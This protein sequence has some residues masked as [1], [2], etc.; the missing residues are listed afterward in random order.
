MEGIS[1]PQ[2]L[3]LRANDLAGEW[4]RWVRSFSDYLLAID[5]VGTSGA[6]ER[7]KL[8]LFR[9][10]GGEDVRELY[11]QM[12]FVGTDN[13]GN[14]EEIA[15]GATGRKIDDVLKRFREYCNPRSGVIV[16]RYTFHNC[17][18][19]GEPVDVY[20]MKLRR[21][22]ESCEF[23]NQRDSLIRD[24]LLFGLDDHKLRDKMMREPDER[25]TLDY[26]IK[27]LRIAE[28]SK[29]AQNSSEK[30]TEV[31][32][33]TSH[34]NGSKLGNDKPKISCNKCGRRHVRN[35]C[36]AFGTTCRKCKRK[37]HWESV[38][39]NEVT[40]AVSELQVADNNEANS[41]EVF[42]GEIFDIDSV[43][44]EAGSW[45]SNVRV[46]TDIK[47]NQL[48]RFKLDTGA[49]LSVCGPQHCVGTQYPS[50]K[51]L[52]G[53]GRTLLNCI[54]I[55]SGKLTAGREKIT[56]DIY[57]IEN[58]NTPLLSR[59]ACESLKFVT[60]DKSR[61][62]IGSIRVS[63]S[64]FKGLG[65]LDTE[66]S[67]T[68]DENAKPF[69]LHV[70]RPIPFPLR[71]KANIALEKMVEDG[72]IVAIEEPTQW[73][74]PMVVVPKPGQDK[75]RICTDFT[76]LNKYVLREVHP[77]AT[78]EESLASIRGGKVF[79]KID[80]NSGFWQIPLSD[81]S[82][83]LTTFIT[84]RGRYRY[85]RLPQGLNSAPEIFQAEMNR[86]LGDLEGLIVHMDDI[87]VVGQST[88]QHDSRLSVVLRRLEQAGMT[89]NKSKCQFGVSKV[90][91]LG[92]VIDQFGIHTG[93]RVQGILEFPT[94][95]NVTGVRSFL[96]LANQYARFSPQLADVTKP[97]RDLLRKDVDWMWGY[98]QQE[99][100]QKVKEIFANPPVLAT[101]DPT[102][103]TIITTDASNQGLG[104]TL[105]QVQP[106]GTRRLVA[107]ASRSLSDTEQRYAAIEKEA[108]GVCWALEKFSQYILG[109]KK[110]LIETDHK[111]LI[112]LF[113]NLFLDRLPAR[114]QGFKLR[115]QIRL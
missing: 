11:S 7:R 13:E 112:T 52:Y 5:L 78:V 69:A 30:P 65:K 32:F 71:Q 89:L 8:A 40:Q 39:T 36:P 113:G 61:C 70:P 58:Q 48:M 47:K 106:D 4:R 9:H 63:D 27:A 109:M 88:E 76:E 68:L 91:F 31:S 64:L 51:K 93:P 14:P 73:V 43:G 44:L 41:D 46:D 100:F 57:V 45:Y 81:E 62:E 53:P 21:A 87:L 17:S 66:Y 15:E 79:S 35:R 101:Y 25:L 50:T 98:G 16:S 72:V 86:I 80:A 90:Q 26:V 55:I 54:G 75:V 115:L 38:C 49:A 107:A 114:I 94:P 2:Q 1:P 22:A 103:E 67:I 95:A 3:D 6:N 18:Q 74:A 42:L 37:N 105:S 96:G 33:V 108:L 59:K 10:V 99:A 84:H 77:M 29:N 92:Y 34:K 102:R 104:A 110:V 56:E 85:L 111:P 60:V 19:S 12:E 82:S 28:V 24:K 97:L 20:L 83:K 23:G